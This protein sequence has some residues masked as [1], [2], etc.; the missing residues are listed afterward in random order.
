ME[1]YV[2]KKNPTYRQKLKIYCEFTEIICAGSSE[3]Y[4]C[5]TTDG[6]IFTTETA[7]PSAFLGTVL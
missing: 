4:S 5:K 1:A 3:A 7:Y 6:L 2:W